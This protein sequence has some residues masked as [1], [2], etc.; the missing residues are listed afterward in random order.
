MRSTSGIAIA[1]SGTSTRR[2]STAFQRRDDR[3]DVDGRLA[4]P[5]HPVEEQGRRV[6]RVERRDDRRHGTRLGL[7]QVGAG[8]ASAAQAG[9]AARQRT[10][11]PLPDLALD[12]TAADQARERGPAVRHGQSGTSQPIGRCG[13]QVLERRHLARA[14]G[15]AR[16]PLPPAER[17]RRR[18]AIVGEPDPA[19]ESRPAG[20]PRQRP[21]ERDRTDIGEATQPAQEAGTT[22]RAGQVPHRASAAGQLVDE[23]GVHGIRRDGLAPVRGQF[24]DELQSLEQARRQHRAQH[25]RRR[26]EVP[27]GDAS[28]PAPG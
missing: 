8:R 1:I 27:G 24:G 26:R 2:R 4:T 10:T 25:E 18:P 5:R 19:L 17:T 9:R 22:F 6:P 14:Q 13:A 23:V 16:Q 15:T 28:A 20:R 7:G 11:W 21:I 3:L 12:E